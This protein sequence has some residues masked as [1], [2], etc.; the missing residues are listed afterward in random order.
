[1]QALRRIACCFVLASGA[2]AAEPVQAVFSDPTTRYTHGVLGDA[3][4]W[5][6]LE[7]TAGGK[8]LRVV[9]PQDRVFEDLLPRLWD[10]TGDGQPEIIVVETQ[11][12]QGAQLAIYDLA[13]TKIAAT[14]HIGQ[15]QRWLAPVGAADMDGDGNVEIAYVDRPHLAKLL[16]IWRFEAGQLSQVAELPNLTNHRIGQDFITGGLRNCDDTP[17][18]VVVSADWQTIMQVVYDD[19]GYAAASRGRFSGQSSVRDALAC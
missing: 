15:A 14:P 2:A 11:A 7:I 1:M 6:S 4:E 18:L 19:G 12:E 9:L 10:I 8:S 3:V 17:A 5:G 16:K 13:G